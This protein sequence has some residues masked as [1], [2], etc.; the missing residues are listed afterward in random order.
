LCITVRSGGNYLDP[1]TR[2]AP[3]CVAAGDRSGIGGRGDDG[4]AEELASLREVRVC[5]RQPPERVVTGRQGALLDR[6]E[7]RELACDP[8]PLL[9]ENVGVVGPEVA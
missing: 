4:H 9:A 8:H 1:A 6:G 2:I 5:E 7:F 3:G